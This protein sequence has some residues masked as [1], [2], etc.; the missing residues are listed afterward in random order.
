MLVDLTSYLI[1][2]SQSALIHTREMYKLKSESI[3][4]NPTETQNEKTAIR[5]TDN[6][7]RNMTPLCTHPLRTAQAGSCFLLIVR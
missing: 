3:E 7:G 5:D 6:V 1:T 2:E 4:R